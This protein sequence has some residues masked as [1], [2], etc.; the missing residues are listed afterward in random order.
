MKTLS[1][2]VYNAYYEEL[3]EAEVADQGE[4]SEEG[5]TMFFALGVLH[6][7]II[8]MWLESGMLHATSR[9]ATVT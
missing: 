5:T 4:E 6:A 7:I 8:T 2:V 9:D 3:R 1:S